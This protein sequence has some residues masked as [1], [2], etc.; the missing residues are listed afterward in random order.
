M[1]WFRT[2]LVYMWTHASMVQSPYFQYKNVLTK[3]CSWWSASILTLVD[4]R[5]D[6]CVIN[7]HY[8]FRSWNIQLI[9]FLLFHHDVLRKKKISS[10]GICYR[11]I[12]DGCDQLFNNCWNIVLAYYAIKGLFWWYS[13]YNTTK[14]SKINKLKK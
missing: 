2:R 7:D 4:N 14:Q 6:S 12:L 9:F 3:Q 1:V 10:Q 11:N 5:Q 8:L 13:K